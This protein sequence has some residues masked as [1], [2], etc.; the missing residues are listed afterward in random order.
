VVHLVAPRAEHLVFVA[1]GVAAWAHLVV[2]FAGLR[3]ATALAA[4]RNMM[5]IGAL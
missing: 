5:E 3:V 4:G 2:G 1:D